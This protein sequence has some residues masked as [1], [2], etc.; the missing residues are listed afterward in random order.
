MDLHLGGE[1]LAAMRGPNPFPA[2]RIA[3]YAETP[4]KVVFPSK[5]FP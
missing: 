2:P 5:Q 1:G 4:A 3:E